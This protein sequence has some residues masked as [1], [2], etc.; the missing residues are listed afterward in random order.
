MRLIGTSLEARAELETTDL[1]KIIKTWF[2]MAVRL[3]DVVLCDP[4]VG[5]C[6]PDCDVDVRIL[7]IDEVL[8]PDDGVGIRLSVVGDMELEND[9]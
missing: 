2:L 9:W 8:E 4:G 1:L 5:S 6:L 7:V 3:G